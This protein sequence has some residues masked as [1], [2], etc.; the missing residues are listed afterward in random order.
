[1]TGQRK[2]CDRRSGWTGA[3]RC[4]L[5][6]GEGTTTNPVQAVRMLNGIDSPRS[7]GPARATCEI[8]E[9]PT[10]LAA[11]PMAGRLP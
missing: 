4:D 2:R 3:W 5:R 11:G 10:A 9:D 8:T 7:P 6:A 1:M